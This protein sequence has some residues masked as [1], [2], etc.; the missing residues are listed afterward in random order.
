[1]TLSSN[2]I[3]DVL[4]VGAGPTG[5]AC[6]IEAKKAGLSYIVVEQG[7]ITDAIRRFPLNMTFFSTPDLLALDGLPFT[8]TNVRPS[9]AESLQYYRGVAEYHDLNLKLHTAVTAISPA[10]DG[11]TIATARGIAYQAQSVI[12][13]I[14]YYDATNHLN[15][16]GEDLPHVSHYYD[17]P[18]RYAATDVTVIGGRNSA[19]EAALD[20]WRH[21]ARVT[22][23]H[24]KEDLGKSVKYWVRPDIE[25]RIKNGD[26]A[27]HFN[28][29][30][31][32]ITPEA[33]HLEN[34]LTGE[35][36]SIHSDFVFP[37]IGYRPDEA[38]LRGA[39]VELS[40]ILIPACNPATFETNVPRLYVAG[41]VMCGCETWS[42]FIEN[43]RNHA[44][45]V[46][47][48]IVRQLVA[49]SDSMMATSDGMAS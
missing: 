45:P 6:A 26:I 16:E 4:I 3:F 9:R 7:S 46:V 20:L 11:F 40:P 10:D 39:G 36:S 28:S 14:G 48:D 12:V 49:T 42:I 8:T 41:S 32:R 43:G 44:K 13:A 34:T 37:L 19:V 17:E 2:H 15:V 47:A 18:Y 35:Q 21:G 27:V 1:M 38:L 33:V 30:V 23:V 29:V 22:M 24:R 5:L 25:N 31:Q